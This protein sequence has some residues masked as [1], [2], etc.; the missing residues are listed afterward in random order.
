[1]FVFLVSSYKIFIWQSFK[2]TIVDNNFCNTFDNKTK[3]GTF[4]LYKK[5]Y[6]DL[7]WSSSL[8]FNFTIVN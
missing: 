5:I 7:H 1:M 3:T 4:S 6:Q 2:V 8:G